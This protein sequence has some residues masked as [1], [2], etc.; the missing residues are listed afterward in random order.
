MW[1][2]GLAATASSHIDLDSP[3][4][5]TADSTPH[6]KGVWAEVYASTAFDVTTLQVRGSSTASSGVNTAQLLDIGIGAS[7]FE[8]VLIA[9][10]P[11]GHSAL[12]RGFGKY[13]DFPISVP[14]GTRITARLQAA[15][16]SDI[17]DIAIDL[18]GATPWDQQ[19]HFQVVDTM[20]TTAAASHGK[21]IT[22]NSITEII[23]STAENYKALG[24]SVDTADETT[25][26][27]EDFTMDILVGAGAAEKVLTSVFWRSD[28]G[29]RSEETMPPQ[30]ILPMILNVPSGSRLSVQRQ[31]SA[32]SRSGV[33]LYGFR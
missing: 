28:N 22:G 29:E 11:T 17:C 31:P 3:V 10:I 4:T 19:S 13:A 23:A 5:I 20:G 25:S 9:D 12:G 1:L 27:S 18:Y 2:P 30:G 6:T 33:T 16:I 15:V 8:K 32:S 14:A 7:T 24:W 21:L 26:G